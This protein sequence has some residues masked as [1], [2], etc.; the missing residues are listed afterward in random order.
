MTRPVARRA[1]GGLAVVEIRL[2][3]AEAALLVPKSLFQIKCLNCPIRSRWPVR[4]SLAIPHFRRG[5]T[6]RRLQSDF[7]KRPRLSTRA[8]LVRL[9]IP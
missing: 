2:A 6:E 1:S 4:R 8:S 9:L 3:D 5:Q 7:G